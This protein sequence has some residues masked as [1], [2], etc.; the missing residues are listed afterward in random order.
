MDAVLGRRI[1]RWT[2]YDSIEYERP[3]ASLQTLEVRFNGWLQYE[4]A[5]LRRNNEPGRTEM[6]MGEQKK[7][8]QNNA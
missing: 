7:K 4:N 2:P 8:Q 5:F 3:H 6:A 1:L